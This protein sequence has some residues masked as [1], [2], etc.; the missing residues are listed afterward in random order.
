ML[1]VFTYAYVVRYPRGAR[2]AA[3]YHLSS[4]VPR[5]AEKAGIAVHAARRAAGEGRV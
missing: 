4:A 5:R 2:G 3:G 1:F